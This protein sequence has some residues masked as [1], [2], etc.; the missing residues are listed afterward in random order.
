MPND[1][2]PLPGHGAAVL[3]GLRV[4]ACGPGL[5]WSGPVAARD[6]DSLLA[7]A[8]LRHR[9]AGGS[10]PFGDIVPDA[11]EPELLEAALAGFL[12]VGSGL[13]QTALEEFARVLGETIRSALRSPAWR[14][15]QRLVVGG[16][17]FRLARVAEIALGRTS[18][19]LR[20]EGLGCTVAAMRH[21][22]EE[23]ALLGAARLLPMRTLH[24]SDAVVT[25]LV[26]RTGC[27]AA[28]VLPRLG[29]APELAAAGIWR[30]RSWPAQGRA[31]RATAFGG[32]ATLLASLTAEASA[33]G[34]TLAPAVAIGVAAAVTEEGGLGDGAAALPG[35]WS[36]PDLLPAAALLRRL[37]DPAGTV[38]PAVLLHEVPVMQGL[39]EAAFHR[40]VARWGVLTIGGDAGHAR[41]TNLPL[42]H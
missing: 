13:V 15:T 4:D 2:S 25:A 33:A 3:R 5:P 21:P 19:L 22:A 39:S 18:A 36:A 30:M 31:D 32:L 26:G 34:L 11:V 14:G 7:D 16:D 29:V 17:G 24:G 23:A 40:D 10:D 20:G 35:D 38:P 1:L 12:P 42:R 37:H 6:F 9:R 27:R 28:V 8:R 41:F